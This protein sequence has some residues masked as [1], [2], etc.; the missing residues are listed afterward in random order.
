MIH[1]LEFKLWPFPI[2]LYREATHLQCFPPMRGYALREGAGLRTHMNLT[3]FT[4]FDHYI[5]VGCLF[6]LYGSITH[7]AQL[8][9]SIRIIL[10]FLL[11]VWSPGKNNKKKTSCMCMEKVRKALKINFRGFKF[12]D[13]NQSRGVALLHKR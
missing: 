7:L 4:Q 1:T 11:S 2:D 10:F 13:S 5:V 8:Q 6:A 3:T 12:R 9:G